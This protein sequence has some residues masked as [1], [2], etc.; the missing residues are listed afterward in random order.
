MA[1]SSPVSSNHQL[2]RLADINPVFCV[3]V[4]LASQESV[5]VTVEF[6][7]GASSVVLSCQYSKKLEE[8][9]TVKW[10][11]LDLSPST[12]HQRREGDDLREQNEFFKGRTSM[13]PD[14]LDSGDFSLTLTEPRLCDIGTYICSLQYETEEITVSDVQLKVTEKFPTWAIVV[15]TFLVIFIILLLFFIILCIIMIRT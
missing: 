5:T 12:V 6:Q 3:F 13:K 8:I 2:E 10:S 4:L 7:E 15:L 9:A 14:A 11:R 1:M